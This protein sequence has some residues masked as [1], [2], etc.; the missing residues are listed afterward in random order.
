MN[1]H[2]SVS[3]RPTPCSRPSLGLRRSPPD[4]LMFPACKDV[5]AQG[6]QSPAASLTPGP[7]PADSALGRVPHC[8]R[9]CG[10]RPSWLRGRCLPRVNA[11]PPRL[12]SAFAF[13]MKMF[14]QQARGQHFCGHSQMFLTTLDRTHD[15]SFRGFSQ[16]LSAP[17]NPCRPGVRS[18]LE[19]PA[20][21]WCRHPRP[22]GGAAPRGSQSGRGTEAIQPLSQAWSPYAPAARPMERQAL[23]SRSSCLQRARSAGGPWPGGLGGW[24]RVGAPQS[25]GGRQ[26]TQ[27]QPARPSPEGQRWNV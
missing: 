16:F 5:Q 18:V 8:G 15:G 25:L 3:H 20:P 11:Q 4:T 19:P 6:C 1:E 24:V 14:S 12:T 21:A 7:A 27:T 23:S 22:P 2:V 9:G 17:S 10:W 13:H 26:V